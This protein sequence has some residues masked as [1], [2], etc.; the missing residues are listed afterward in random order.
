MRSDRRFAFPRPRQTSCLEFKLILAFAL[1]T[2]VAPARAATIVGPW[3]P[4]F[5]SIDYSVSTNLPGGDFPNRHVVHAFRVDLTD[6]DIRFFTTPRISSYSAGVREIGALTV[7]DFLKTY[8]VQAAINAN[9]FSGRSYYL[10]AYT[11]MDVYGLQI[12][13]GVVVSA[14]DGPG[15]AASILFDE[16]NRA[17]IIHTNWPA[18]SVAGVYTAISGNYP[19][20]VAGR[21]I[22]NRSAAR[23]VDP[24]TA[25]GVSQDRR[26]FYLMGIDG[27]QSGYSSGANDYE[28]AGWLLLLGA[29]DGVN[30]DG[31]G[32]TTLVIEDSTGVPRRLN[33]S[34]AVADSG[35]E[36][37]V[38]SHFGIFAKPLP[39]FVNNVVAVPDDTTA[40]IT[41]TTIEPATTEVEFGPTTNFGD[42]SGVLSDLV[43]QH[44]VEL[45]GLKPNTGYYY[46]A[47]ST[48]RSQ[49]YTSPNLYFVTTNYVTTNQIFGLTNSWRFS[50]ASLDG[51]D[52]TS[53]S[54]DDA[55]WSGPEPAL[56][57]VDV[58][59]AGPNALVEPKN[60]EMPADPQNSGYPHVTYYFRTRFKVENLVPGS[61]LAF[62]GYVDDGAVFYLNGTEIYR[63]RMPARSD[64]GTLAIGYPCDGDATCLD[65]FTIPA[66]ATQNLVLGD[67]VLAVE[68]H[69][70]NLRS[71]DITF[72]VSMSR[73][74][75]IARGARLAIARSAGTI[76]LSWDGSGL[77]LQ[78]ADAIE[79][80]WA[81]VATNPGS[82][83]TVQP[84]ASN[85]FYRLRK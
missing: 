48:A 20:V 18:A 23:E 5:K 76:A 65:E 67:N 11:P 77:V 26:Y 2:T 68:V 22:V 60:T 70:Y 64:A 14:A 74:E 55:A 25:F 84:A 61:S 63:L 50:T 51:V 7:S 8:K 32:S 59:A 81:D 56:L 46:R 33:R 3:G 53:R 78:S 17:T 16:T 52:W 36:R 4:I 19:L 9:F 69:N 42:S 35:R 15:H 44:F 72:G 82:P 80:P 30:M 47:V 79:G 12:S 27:R 31:G 75:P 1:L 34:S 6:P 57:W 24:R 39:G 54:F 28:T 71:A 13:E 38:G 45:K 62:S 41:W 85:R 49:Q 73:I 40:R 83:F 58:R 66:E 10:P 43:T 37:T 21:N 29:H